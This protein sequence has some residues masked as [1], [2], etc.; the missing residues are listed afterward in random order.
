MSYSRLLLVEDELH[1]CDW[2]R[3]EL[4][5]SFPDLLVSTVH[6]L[7]SAL[8]W[9]ESPLVDEMTLA[10]V[11]LHLNE[12]SGTEI[13]QRISDSFPAVSVLVLTSVDEPEEALAAIRAGAQGY[14]LKNTLKGELARSVEQ[15]RKGGSP[16]SPG[17]AQ[18][19][20][21]S[22]RQQTTLQPTPSLN[23]PVPTDLL[24]E[25]TAR[26]TEVFNYLARGFSDKEV[27]ARMGIAPST[28]D[29]HVRS[30][31]RKLSINS[32]SQLRNLISKYQSS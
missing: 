30:V 13:I 11:D 16:I 8:N 20:L 4:E 21:Q 5:A 18:M 23:Q 14:M 1:F 26:E 6:D 12:D 2:A 27:A 10:I 3:K 17:I 9:L 32:R 15:I 22:F 7:Q 28:V 29:T 19:V 24:S 31:Y 25:L